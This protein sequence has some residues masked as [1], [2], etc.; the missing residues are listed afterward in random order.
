MADSKPPTLPQ[1]PKLNRAQRRQAERLVKK[2][3]ATKPTRR[4]KMWAFFESSWFWGAFG[5]V[6]VLIGYV[7]PPLLVGAWLCLCIAFYRS[8][9]FDRTKRTR[10]VGNLGAAVVFAIMLLL[11]WRIFKPS[12]ISALE[13]SELH[14][15]Q[16]L[17]GAKDESQLRDMF[18]YPEML[19]L[20]ILLV[21]QRLDPASLD[22]DDTATVAEYQKSWQAM[23]TLRYG[24]LV[25][26]KSSSEPLTIIPDKGQITI[27][28]LTSKYQSEQAKVLQFAKSVELSASVANSV[29]VFNDTLQANLDLMLDTLNQDLRED[30]N[31]ITHDEDAHPP[32][33]HRATERYWS[34]FQNLQPKAD[35]VVAA[36]RAR[37]K[38]D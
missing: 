21:R 29:N 28:G 26:P 19:K 12:E 11:F 30:Q 31:L 25:R 23:A 27:L 20:N 10:V 14:D 2:M 4:Q 5:V 15:L 7:A 32:Y 38:T 34:R 17:V 35:A 24:I 9:F 3:A 8:G 22:A 18:D 36:I 6:L 16:T 37:L 13:R 1:P 33:Y